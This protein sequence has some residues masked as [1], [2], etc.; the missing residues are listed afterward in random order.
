[1]ATRV[2]YLLLVGESNIPDS[3]YVRPHPLL[4][5]PPMGHRPFYH[6]GMA[7]VGPR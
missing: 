4:V 7:L 1:M 3:I 5:A 2:V 6:S